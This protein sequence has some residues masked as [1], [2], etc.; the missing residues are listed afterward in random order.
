M[1]LINMLAKRSVVWA[2]PAWFER[3]RQTVSKK[4]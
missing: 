1:I 2:F 3:K 4:I